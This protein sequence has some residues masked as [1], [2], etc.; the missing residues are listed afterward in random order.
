MLGT[1][2]KAIDGERDTLVHMIEVALALALVLAATPAHATPTPEQRAK[3]LLDIQAKAIDAGDQAALDATLTSDVIALV[4]D[5]RAVVA[6]HD[7]DAIRRTSPHESLN[8]AKVDKIVAGGDANAVWISAELWPGAG[9]IPCDR[10][11]RERS[12]RHRYCW[13]AGQNQR[14]Y[15]AAHCSVARHCGHG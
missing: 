6:H 15:C 1:R 3:T 13:Q 10:S 5:P 8:S 12:G 2:V 4:P 14:W 9:S 11:A 7:I